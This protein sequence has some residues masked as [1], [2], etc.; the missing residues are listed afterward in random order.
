M[1]FFVFFVPCGGDN[2]S[3]KHVGSQHDSVLREDICTYTFN[4]NNNLNKYVN[5]PL[6]N[7]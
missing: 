6:K 3:T 1:L 5:L 4:F 2:I 7:I